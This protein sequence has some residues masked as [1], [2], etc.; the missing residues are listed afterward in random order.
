[1]T[2]AR[3]SGSEVASCVARTRRFARR[4]SNEEA[5]I[6]APPASS[7]VCSCQAPRRALRSSATA[8]VTTRAAASRKTRTA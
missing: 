7:V 6:R 1:V 3:W 4:E 8:T 5:P 2:T